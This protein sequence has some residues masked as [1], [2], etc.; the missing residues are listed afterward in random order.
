M[1]TVP[2]IDYKNLEMPSQIS[3]HFENLIKPT[4]SSKEE[5]WDRFVSF[6]GRGICLVR[7]AD[8]LLHVPFRIFQTICRI[9]YHIIGVFRYLL[10]LPFD[11]SNNK[12]LL[13]NSFR[14]YMNQVVGLLITP[15]SVSMDITKLAI[16]VIIHPAAAI[17]G[18][19]S[20]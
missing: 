5:G 16:G 18:P 7:I 13:Y 12:E 1:G 8:Y 4:M 14:M 15:L 2:T 6:G 3:K 19:P 9:A 10:L 20:L 11:Y 17:A